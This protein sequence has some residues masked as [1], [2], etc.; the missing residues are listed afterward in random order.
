MAFMGQNGEEDGTDVSEKPQSPKHSSSAAEDNHGTPMK[1]SSEVDASEVSETAQSPKQPSKLEETHRIS[2]GSSVSKVDGS[3]QPMTLQ[4]PTHPSAAEEKGDGSTESPTPKGDVSEVSEPSQSPTHPSTSK[5]NHSGSI[6]TISSTRE[7][8][9]DQQVSEHSGPNDE[10]L[11]SQL[12]EFGGD[13]P[14]DGRASS[15]PTKL[16][17]SSDMETAGSI[18][19]GKE[20]T[21][22]GNASQSQPAD[23]MLGNSDDANEVE[24]TIVQESDVQKEISTPQDSSDTVDRLTHIEVTARDDNNNTADNEDESNQTEAGVAPVIGQED[25][26]REHLEDLGSKSTISGHDSNLQSELS[27]TS[28]DM[29]AGPVEV[30]SPAKSLR[31]EE[32]MEESIKSTSSLTLESVGSVIE[33]EKLR[34]E[35]KMMEAALQ[36]AAR[37]SQSKADEIARL[38]NENEQLKSTID[39]LKSKSSEAEMDALKDEY[40]QRVATLERKVYALTK[41]RDTLRREQNKKK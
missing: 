37:Q 29:P 19:A 1:P 25:N 24:G 21:A 6:E 20:D 32:K 27:V 28:A 40:H 18:C 16:D 23:S 31:K 22:D 13:T 12:G 34:C 38:M 2:T 39:D 10:S 17:Q 8:N 7:E 15:S 11:P 4:A 33:L 26:A 3:E 41:E 36:G 35:I 9:Q 30:A 5:E 14:D